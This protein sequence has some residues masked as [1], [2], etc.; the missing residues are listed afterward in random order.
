MCCLTFSTVRMYIY[1]HVFRMAHRIFKQ[2]YYRIGFL[3]IYSFVARRWTLF[4]AELLKRSGKLLVSNCF[5]MCLSRLKQ[6]FAYFFKTQETLFVNITVFLHADQ[7][8]LMEPITNKRQ[9]WEIRTKDYWSGDVRKA[10]HVLLILSNKDLHETRSK[11]TENYQQP[12]SWTVCR[13]YM[14][15]SVL[16]VSCS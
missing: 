4:S 9:K 3:L 12:C 5:K 10:V 8:Q 7:W 14:W 2:L 11:P 1:H 6:S 13:C 16:Y 15:S